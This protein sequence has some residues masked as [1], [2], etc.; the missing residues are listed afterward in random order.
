MKKTKKTK[1]IVLFLLA[2]LFVAM[3]FLISDTIAQTFITPPTC[4]EGDGCMP[5]CPGGPDPDC[6]VVCASKQG[7]GGL[8]PCGK[9][10][11]DPDTSWNECAECNTCSM[12][13]MGQLIIEY[14]VTVTAT[15]EVLRIFIGGV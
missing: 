12:I 10:V 13:L 7:S 2:I 8:I 4:S 15:I 5:N 14:L 6:G 1:K 9:S 3:P 11:N